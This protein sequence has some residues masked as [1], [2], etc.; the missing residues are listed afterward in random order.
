MSKEIQ[1]HSLFRNVLVNT[2]FNDMI[3][4]NIKKRQ[5][6][7]LKQDLCI[8]RNILLDRPIRFS[9][10]FVLFI[11]SVSGSKE[12]NVRSVTNNCAS[13]SCDIT[14]FCVPS[15]RGSNRSQQ[16]LYKPPDCGPP[17]Q[18][19]G[20]Y[21]LMSGTTLGHNATVVCHPGFTLDPSDA[22]VNRSCQINSLW[23]PFLGACLKVWK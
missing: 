11:L 20:G 15:F 8:E 3:D 9:Q 4:E 5:F 2:Y 17:G 16:C 7:N 21:Y 18:V 12:L 19:D 22:F 1:H 14:E 6:Q 23:T 13:R 10:R